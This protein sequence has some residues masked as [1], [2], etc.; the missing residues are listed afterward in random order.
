LKTRSS[1]L[2]IASEP[3]QIGDLRWRVKLVDSLKLYDAKKL[4]ALL[5]RITSSS[6]NP[7]TPKERRELSS[8]A[9]SEKFEIDEFDMAVLLRSIYYPAKRVP[10]IT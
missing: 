4:T 2:F 5:Q 6:D 3:D 1:E 8:L 9:I 10:L 7:L